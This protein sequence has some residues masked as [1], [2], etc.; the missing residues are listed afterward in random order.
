M[1]RTARK[2][3]SLIELLVVL[4]VI[5]LLIA[6]LLPSLKQSRAAARD[7]VCRNQL[8]QTQISTVAYTQDH[9]FVLPPGLM[10]DSGDNPGEWDRKLAHKYL[11]GGSKWYFHAVFACPDGERG[12][13]KI[14]KSWYAAPDTSDDNT[15]GRYWN[16]YIPHEQVVGKQWGASSNYWRRIDRQTDKHVLYVEKR[17]RNDN[18]V[19]SHWES[20]H[21]VMNDW[22]TLNDYLGA[23]FYGFQHGS[24][25][26]PQMNAVLIDGRVTAVKLSK[27]QSLAASPYSVWTTWY[28]RLLP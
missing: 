11:A 10:A 15:N 22:P 14:G 5:S 20:H 21:R 19:G 26:D 8:R 2:G 7:V 27:F 23:N 17:D 16:S 4:S 12:P 1:N 24:P 25:A 9:A 28:R 6:L 13:K 3:F 18:W